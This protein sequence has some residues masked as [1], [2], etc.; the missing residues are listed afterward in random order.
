[1][2]AGL[3]LSQFLR[4]QGPEQWWLYFMFCPEHVFYQTFRLQILSALLVYEDAQAEPSD[5]VL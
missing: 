4:L 3:R 2:Q 1:M 5:L